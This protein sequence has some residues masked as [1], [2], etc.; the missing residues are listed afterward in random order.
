MRLVGKFFG[1]SPFKLLVEHT[2]EVHECVKL[3]KPLT[4]ALIAGDHEKIEALHHEMSSKEHEADLTKAQIRDNLSK[5][6][7]LSVG[8]YELDQ[9]LSLQDNVADAAEDYA[10]VLLLRKTKVPRELNEDFVALVSQ[11][12]L[13]SEHLLSLSEELALLEEAAFTGVEARRVLS[14]IDNI[15]EEEWKADKLQRK[16][17]R[18][19][20][21]MEDRLE[22]ITIYFLDK[23]CHTLSQIANTA[24][25]AAKFLRQLIV[26]R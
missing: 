11:V 20:Y 26:K 12:V 9:F 19:F 10:V 18:R 7:L 14:C 1:A 21:A 3:V 23:Y 24:E 22:P 4:A 17:A 8:R 13:V 25:K 16:F 5:M 2:R 6:F 15:G